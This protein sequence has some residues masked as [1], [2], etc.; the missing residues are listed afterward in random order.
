MYTER[1]MGLPTD[2]DNK[3]GYIASSLLTNASKL[4]KKFLLIH[5]TLD[6]N[7]HYQQSMMFARV[8]EL[9]DILFQQQVM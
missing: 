2:K 3:I 5:G 4:N 6:D 9:N 7:V 8:L 1:F